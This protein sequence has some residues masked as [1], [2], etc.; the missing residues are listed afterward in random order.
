MALDAST[1]ND[2]ARF[3][4]EVRDLLG[5]RLVCLA[6]Y[7]SAATGHFVPERS[8]VNCAVVVTRVTVQVLDDL[9][10]VVARWRA[11]RFALPLLVDPEYLERAC[12]TFPM[13]LDDLR[14]G[15]RLL[16]GRDVFADLRTTRDALRIACERE[17]RGKQLRL[18]AL[19]LETIGRDAAFEQV[20]VGSLKSF[21][22]LLRHLLALHGR[23]MPHDHGAVLDGGEALLGPL[24]AM[25]RLLA[26]RTGTA[27]RPVPALR[28]DF[29]TYLDEID[30]IV[31]ATD[32]LDA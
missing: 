14:R 29:A 26:H 2:I 11:K 12:D 25:R 1:E 5:E 6:L 9:A 18:R 3:A 10:P 20:M 31:V 4:T 21:L 28:A 13:E 22:V 7:G 24:P 23:P 15:H 16:A 30:R 19:Y 32:R 8:D 17:A 27:S